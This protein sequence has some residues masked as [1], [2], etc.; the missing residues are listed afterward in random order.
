[1]TWYKHNCLQRAKM[2]QFKFILIKHQLMLYDDICRINYDVYW[3][4]K[5]KHI[6]YIQEM[7]VLLNNS[8]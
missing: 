7:F 5:R 6:L 8:I 1:M 3:N 2:S 4:F